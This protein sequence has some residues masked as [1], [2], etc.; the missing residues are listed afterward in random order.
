MHLPIMSSS[1]TRQRIATSS[2]ARRLFFLGMAIVIGI[3]SA[4]VTTAAWRYIAS[5]DP[6]LLWRQAV[7]DMQAGRI[8]DAAAGLRRLESLRRTTPDDLVLRAEIF[9]AQGRDDAALDAIRCVPDGHPLAGQAWYLAGRIERQNHRL[10][11]A[12]AAFRRA[13]EI[14]PTLILA[15]KELVYI[16]GIQLRRREV[17]AEFKA[18]SRLTSLSHRD[19]FTWCVT[20]FSVWAPGIF[21]DLESSIQAD[22]ADRFSQLALARLL[23][24]KSGMENWFERTLERLPPSDLEAMS[25]R[26]EF[27]LIH[28]RIGEAK[29]LLDNA[30]SSRRELARL[31]GQAALMRGEV[32]S[33]I[34]HFKS[35]L[36]DDEPYDRVLLSELGRALSINGEKTSAASYLARARRL[37]DLYFLLAKNNEPGQEI[38][39]SD[40]AQFARAC[41]AAGLLSEARGWYLLA[42]AY[43][44]LD[45]EAQQ[46]LW[47]LREV[48]SRQRNNLPAP[49][50]RK[51][52]D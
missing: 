22:P 14:E 41:E 12:E 8:A 7:V 43:D 39:G 28:G 52:A 24:D 18:L 36:S 16:L 13:I 11:H 40:S 44:P 26:I 21:N 30:P 15:H 3:P 27:L 35:A 6:D 20:H 23:V 2:R 5:P 10:R 34:S 1:S 33:A 51:A 29:V 49:A 25:L 48:G 31:R 45:F 17:D 32:A 42:I 19:M 38:R 9:S 4:L 46:A 50:E 47:R 37:D